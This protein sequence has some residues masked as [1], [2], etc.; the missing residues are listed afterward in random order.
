[1][2]RVSPQILLGID[3]IRFGLGQSPWLARTGF[4]RSLIDDIEQILFLDRAP[5]VNA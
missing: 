5:S 1:M 2:R 3:Q 4:E